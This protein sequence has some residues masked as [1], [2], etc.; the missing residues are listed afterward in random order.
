[1]S[2]FENKTEGVICMKNE[3]ENIVITTESSPSTIT[4]T[5]FVTHPVTSTNVLIL[6]VLILG[7]MNK[8]VIQPRW[9]TY[10][11]GLKR[12]LEITQHLN[13]CLY[14]ILTICNADR[15]LL[16]EP[17]NGTVFSSGH[18]SW[19]VSCTSEA[20]ARGV[21]STKSQLQNVPIFEVKNALSKV[22]E[23]G[24]YTHKT[25][26]DILDDFT[27][28]LYISNGVQESLTLVVRNDEHS[29]A[30]AFISVSWLSK[31]HLDNFSIEEIKPVTSEIRASLVGIK[32]NFFSTVLKTLRGN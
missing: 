23:L 2:N 21:S 28:N 12:S 4:I 5:D 1:M 11:T 30:L 32:D 22:F 15:V 29:D 10:T 3:E 25:Q 17:H 9:N 20:L 24:Y 13:G 18:H 6:L 14:K 7:W 27:D 19:K 31:G 8:N 16:L 26:E